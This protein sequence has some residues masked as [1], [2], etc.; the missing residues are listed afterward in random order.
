LSRIH[1]SAF[2]GTTMNEF[3]K[4]G[5]FPLDPNVFPDWKHEPEEKTRSPKQDKLECQK[6]WRRSQ[7]P[8]SK[9]SR[10]VTQT[11]RQPMKDQDIRHW[12]EGKT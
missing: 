11:R 2:T 7:P 8:K 1:E 9:N 12:L 5:I 3:Q 6:S 4:T 10:T